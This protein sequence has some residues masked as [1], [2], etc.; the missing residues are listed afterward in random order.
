MK[1]TPG[2]TD[3]DIMLYRGGFVP[4]HILDL[5]TSLVDRRYAVRLI[6]TIEWETLAD[7]LLHLCLLRLGLTSSVTI[8]ANDRTPRIWI[9]LE[10]GASPGGKVKWSADGPD[11]TVTEAALDYWIRFFL[12]YYKLGRSPVDHIDVLPER[13][14]GEAGKDLHLVL[15]LQ[16]RGTALASGTPEKGRR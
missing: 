8:A 12:D 6:V 7:W 2:A 15:Q 13:H 5:S 1:R 10:P 14:G 9:G 3:A 11:L 4:S 16:Q